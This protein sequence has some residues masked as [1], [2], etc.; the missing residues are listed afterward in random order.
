[1]T[2]KRY[3]KAAVLG[4][5]RR[6]K[7]H[8]KSRKKRGRGGLSKGRPR[9]RK[10][11]RTRKKYKWKKKEPEIISLDSDDIEFGSTIDGQSNDSSS[12]FWFNNN[13]ATV[14]KTDDK[15]KTCE[16][17]GQILFGAEARTHT[18]AY[19]IKQQKERERKRRIRELQRQRN[20]PGGNMGFPDNNAA[21]SN[22][23]SRYR[24]G[25]KGGGRKTRRKGGGHDLCYVNQNRS[26]KNEVDIQTLFQLLHSI[27][28]DDGK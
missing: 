18:T 11:K 2:E 1:M 9:R 25:K 15:M 28:G 17:C 27:A 22:F 5:R 14:D 23:A 3:K 7:I 13:E 12:D 19:C 20:A 8:R 6:Q 4:G 24:G 16:N 26:I 10:R 21:A